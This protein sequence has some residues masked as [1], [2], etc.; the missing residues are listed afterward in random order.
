MGL[1]P[2]RRNSS[3]SAE[4]VFA[5]GRGE[6]VPPIPPVAAF[7]PIA[8]DEHEGGPFLLILSQAVANERKCAGRRRPR[9]A[10]CPG[11]RLDAMIR[12]ISPVELVS[13]R[14]LLLVQ[15]SGRNNHNANVAGISP[16]AS[17]SDTRVW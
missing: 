12:E 16:R 14:A 2:A 15:L 1:P 13:N 4:N 17:V 5:V 10:G 8:E 11:R 9:W 3:V 6:R 7:N